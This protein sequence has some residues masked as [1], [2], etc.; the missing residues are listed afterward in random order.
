MFQRRGKLA[1]R[2]QNQAEVIAL[3]IKSRKRA[4]TGFLDAIGTKHITGL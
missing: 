4:S 1:G 3:T 2:E